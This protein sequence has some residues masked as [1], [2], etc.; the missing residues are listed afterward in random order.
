MLSNTSRRGLLLAAL[1]S[2]ALV[3]SGCATETPYRPATGKGFYRTGYSDRQIEANRFLVTFSG[4]TVTERDTVE[5]YLLFR[6]AQL[7]LQNGYDYFVMV[8]RDTDRQARTYSTGTGFGPYGG[9]GGY[10]GPSWGFYGRGIGGW[11]R[12]GG[13]FGWG[14][15]GGYGF[16]DFDVRT[17]DRF[18]ATAEIVM[19]KGSPGPED[20]RAFNAQQVVDKIGPTVV[21]PKQS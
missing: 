5:R 17:V 13:G 8:Q 18:E 7:T 10:W 9:W 21:L 12:F 2:G 20:V 4:N 6:A 16:N 11:R 1:A 14:G 19:R 3:L 15:W